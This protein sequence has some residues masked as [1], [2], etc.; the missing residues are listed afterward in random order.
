MNFDEDQESSETLRRFL[1]KK[2]GGGSGGSAK[3]GVKDTNGDSGELND[4]GELRGA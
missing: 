3:R 4:E 1:A 2:G